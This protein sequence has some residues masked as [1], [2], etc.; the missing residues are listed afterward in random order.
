M[1]LAKSPLEGIISDY[2]NSIHV[3]F[4]YR[5]KNQ[6][7]VFLSGFLLL[8]SGSFLFANTLP[9][10]PSISEPYLSKF[11]LFIRKYVDLPWEKHNFWIGWFLG[12]CLSLIIFCIAFSFY[13]YWDIQTERK[14][15][16]PRLLAF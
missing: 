9:I 15:L 16:K 3:R 6:W 12:F 1:T 8:I 11:F 4:Q 10:L 5:L 14:S 7:K 2:Y 13:K